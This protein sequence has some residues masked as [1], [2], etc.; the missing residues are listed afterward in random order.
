MADALA[1]EEKQ[2]EAASA[3]I[4]LLSISKYK[5]SLSAVWTARNGLLSHPYNGWVCKTPF[6]DS[7]APDN[8]RQHLALAEKWIIAMQGDDDGARKIAAEAA[9]RT[10]LK[11]KED[12]LLGIN[13]LFGAGA[14]NPL[15]FIAIGLGA[16]LVAGAVL[17]MMRIGKKKTGK[18]NSQT[19]D[20]KKTNDKQTNGSD[21]K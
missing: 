12:G 16:V 20:K 9:R 19:A 6:Y 8:I 13:A 14:G 11:E 4:S 7:A 15:I 17:V 3:G 21:V 18:E 10:A 2:Y 5:S 1:D